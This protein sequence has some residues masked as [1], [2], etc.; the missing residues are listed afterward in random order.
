MN[1]YNRD[2]DDFYVNIHLNTEM[3]LPTNRDTVLHFFDQL[4]RGFRGLR[5]FHTGEKG[6]LVREGEKQEESYRGVAI[7]PRRLC[8][9]HTTPESLEEAYRQHEMVLD[10]APP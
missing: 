3:E 1:S 10:R 8:W 4:K 2:A 6:D 7:E 5:N 9:G